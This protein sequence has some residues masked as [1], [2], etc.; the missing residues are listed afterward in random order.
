VIFH[1]G[2]YKESNN[3]KPELT[4]K[5]KTHKQTKLFF[6]LPSDNGQDHY[7]KLF[8]Y[9]AGLL[10]GT[11]FTENRQTEMTGHEWRTGSPVVTALLG[12]FSWGQV[13][14]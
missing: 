1:D 4:F 10:M 13:M 12:W 5:L 7:K 6:F 2:L 8:N 3:V 9:T 14:L 11:L